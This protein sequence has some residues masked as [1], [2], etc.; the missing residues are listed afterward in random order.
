MNLNEGVG[1]YGFEKNKAALSNLENDVT[2]LK[3]EGDLLANKE[4]S[5]EKEIQNV[6]SEKIEIK[7][8]TRSTSFSG[9]K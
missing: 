8:S 5:A 1:K 4:K 2:K 9:R 3:N 7:R 6:Q